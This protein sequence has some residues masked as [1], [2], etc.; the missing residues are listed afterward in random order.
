MS[1]VPFYFAD[2]EKPPTRMRLNPRVPW[3]Y[4]VACSL[5]FLFAY[6]GAA[7]AI[8]IF[9]KLFDGLGVDLPLPT[10]FLMATYGWLLPLFFLGAVVLTI[11]KQFVRLDE[12][13]LHFTNL[14]L[15]FVAVVFVPLIV[16]AVYLPL[17]ELIWKLL[18]T[19]IK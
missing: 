3:P 8:P 15:I 4:A 5:Y 7:T 14:V 17:F 1:L 9:A 16:F 10:R 2:E 6:R 18:S 11:V 13:H 19:F 12:L